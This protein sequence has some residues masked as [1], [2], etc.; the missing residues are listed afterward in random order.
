MRKDEEP[1]HGS[2]A[3]ASCQWKGRQ[4]SDFSRAVAWFR[5]RGLS[6]LALGWPQLWVLLMPDQPRAEDP[7]PPC[8]L[9][10]ELT[11]IRPVRILLL[12][13]FCS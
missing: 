8:D 11:A 4:A 2:L 1:P 10:P 9:S 6:R 7:K 13:H 12:F 3:R 5:L